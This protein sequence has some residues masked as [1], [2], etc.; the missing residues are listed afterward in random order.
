VST[1]RL[2]Y[3]VNQYP[4][5][6][7]TFIRREIGALEALG[8]PIRR[9]AIRS[10]AEELTEPADRAERE[11]THVC[12]DQPITRLIVTAVCVALSR[13][14]RFLRATQLAL[15]MHRRSERGLLR[16]LA[17]L[18]EAAYLIPLLQRD[19]ITHV[20][21][22]FGTNA[23]TV[24]RLIQALGGPGYSMTIHGPGEFDAPLGLSLG[25]KVEDARFVV[26]ISYYC[27]AQIRRW[28]GPEHWSKIAI[29]RCGVDRRLLGAHV[30][31]DPDSQVLLNVGRLTAQK[32]QLLLLEA[33]RQVVR[34]HPR[35]RLMLVGDGEMRPL[36][37]RAIRSAELGEH[38]SI[39]GWLPEAEVRRR[40][41]ASRAIVLPSF[42]EGLPVVLMEALALGRPVITTA[43]AGVPELVH[44]GE[45]GWL[46]FAGDSERL[47]AAMRAALDAPAATLET[48]AST[49]HKRVRE[50]H[51]LER[52]ASQLAV[53]FRP[54]VP[55]MRGLDQDRQDDRR[56]THHGGEQS[57]PG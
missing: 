26:A 42:A 14:R 13:P 29:V 39:T 38:V 43:I 22:H 55:E 11:R 36:L 32:G 52:Q 53:L 45:G 35:A 8:I 9:I 1:P 2:A 18:G 50:L 17:Y 27:S 21:V 51:Q 37:E 44:P 56:D 41:A 57:R 5:G 3:L 54:W 25:P 24:A 34:D 30:P 49:G 46:V 48:I 10:A 33:F 7:H 28:V 12:Q 4:K 16:H 40:M 20:H 19:C 23:A 15:R 6:S 31:I 47:A